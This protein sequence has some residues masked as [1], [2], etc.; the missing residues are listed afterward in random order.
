[1]SILNCY[2]T[3]GFSQHGTHM[4][5]YHIYN[6][7]QVQVCHPSWLSLSSRILLALTSWC[8]TKR[9]HSWWGKT[10][11]RATSIAR[12]MCCCQFNLTWSSLGSSKFLLPVLIY[13]NLLW[14]I[15]TPSVKLNKVQVRP[16]EVISSK[17]LHLS[18]ELSHL[19]FL[20]LGPSSLLLSFH[21]VTFFYKL[22]QGISSWFMWWVHQPKGKSYPSQRIS[23]WFMWWVHE[24]KGKSYPSQ[25]ISSWFMWWIDDNPW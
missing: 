5:V 18:L 8:R 16:M 3:N 20:L 15:K 25:R 14:S 11:A 7:S 19:H 13:Q 1:M 17:N 22:S 4:A 2:I 23:S 12:S 9:K 21:Q 10:S 6:S 24:L